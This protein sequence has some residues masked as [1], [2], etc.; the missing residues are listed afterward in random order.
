M[1]LYYRTTRQNA[2]AIAKEGFKD[3]TGTYFTNQEFFGVWVSSE[4]LNANEGACGDVLFEITL[5]VPETSIADYE[6]V[7]EGKPYRGWLM[8]GRNDKCAC[9]IEAGQLDDRG[10]LTAM[11]TTI[12]ST[13]TR[14]KHRELFVFGT[15]HNSLWRITV[16]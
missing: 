3:A 10:V 5:T 9:H 6:W 14:K 15:H 11:K 12:P 4:P 1:I 16:H 2:E 8:P 13:S 7:E